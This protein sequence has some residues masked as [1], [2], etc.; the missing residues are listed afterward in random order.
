MYLLDPA[1]AEHTDASSTGLICQQHLRQA[2]PIAAWPRRLA[3]G[4]L[5]N[6]ADN[7]PS[8]AL[9]ANSPTRQL[10]NSPP[11]DPTSRQS[12]LHSRLLISTASLFYPAHTQHDADTIP[13]LTSHASL[14]TTPIPSPFHLPL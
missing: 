5:A 7:T 3:N 13:F 1:E 14:P 12:H 2:N 6:V 4:S 11:A 10:A 8:A 9:L